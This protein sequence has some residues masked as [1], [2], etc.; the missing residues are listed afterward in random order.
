MTE[1]HDPAFMFVYVINNMFRDMNENNGVIRDTIVRVI[2]TQH[3][4]YLAQK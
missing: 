1:Y 3:P 4:Y 2:T